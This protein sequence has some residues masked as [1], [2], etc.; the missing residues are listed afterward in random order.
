MLSKADN[1]L[2][3]RVEPGTPMHKAFKHYWLPAGLSTDVEPDGAP[4][5]VTLLCEDYV[6]FRDS[7]GR[8]GFMRERCCHRGAS[9]CLGRVEESG[10]R[11][12]YHGWKFA[13]DGSIL[14]M[15]NTTD[16]RFKARYRQP[17]YPIVERGG[18]IWVYLGPADA[19]PPPPDYYWLDYPEA[20][21]FISPVLFETNYTQA[22][23]GGADSS[24]LTILHQDALRRMLDNTDQGVRDRV[25]ADAAPKFDTFDTDFGQF[26]VAIRTSQGSDGTPSITAR[27]SA[28]IALSTVLVTGG[29]RGNAT[30]GVVVPITSEKCVF[31]I[32]M[33]NDQFVDTQAIE[34]ARYMNVDED[35][36]ERLGIGRDSTGREA[37]FSRANNWAQDRSS[38]SDGTLF[39]GLPLF[40]PE[41]IA[42]A[43]S[44]GP[45]YD[46]SEENLVPADQAIVR[47]RRILLDA[48]RNAEAGRLP[49]GVER[50][51]DT[52]QIFTQEVKLHQGDDWREV[53]LPEAFRKR[54]L[55][56]I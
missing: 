1:D 27:T 20:Q 37:K 36:L 8:V 15:P 7:E 31:Y 44:A 16:D 11:C 22:I 18:L 52:A 5:R 14:D 10:I 19:Q 42:V 55:E 26:S 24:H 9:L 13:V 43:E 28:F 49:L 23:D 41:D 35:S 29:D 32:G 2:L 50:P 47:I 53:A 48:A 34:G 51:V 3:C 12:I 39:T 25:L 46:R 40:I 33:F 54:L 6:M 4:R 30:W 17:A 38:M 45:I 21:R 56:S